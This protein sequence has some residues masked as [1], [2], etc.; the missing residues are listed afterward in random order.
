MANKGSHL[1]EET[2]RKL[3]LVLKGRAPW[4]KGKVN[5]YSKERRKRVSEKLKG[6]TFTEEHRKNISE[7][8]KG[9]PGSFK[10][11]HHSK[12]TREKIR[13]AFL[14]R[15]NPLTQKEKHWNWKGGLAH[16]N[17]RRLRTTSEYRSWRRAVLIKDNNACKLCMTS[18]GIL[19]AHHIF[20]W[21]DYPELRFNIANGM[22][23][24][25]ACHFL[26]H[27]KTRPK[28]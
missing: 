6:R 18:G 14:G 28:R 16:C 24:C 11:M 23:L 25:K 26:T 4:N 21:V 2:K 27:R 13:L 12:A 17:S 22:T 7:G 1:S 15:P 19:N 3:R 20:N 9:K 8:K 5:V 10:G